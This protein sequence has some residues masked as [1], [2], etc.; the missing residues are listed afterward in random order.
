MTLARHL[1]VGNDRS[2]N[3]LSEATLTIRTS[4]HLCATLGLV[5]LIR[6][7][8]DLRGTIT[9]TTLPI[10]ALVA[11][12][13][14]KAI[15]GG[16]PA[17]RSTGIWRGPRWSLWNEALPGITSSCRTDTSTLLERG[18]IRGTFQ[19]DC[20]DLSSHQSC[21]NSVMR[22]GLTTK[23]GAHT[24]SRPVWNNTN[25]TALSRMN[26]LR[27]GSHGR[28]RPARFPPGDISLL[29]LLQNDGLGR[30]Q[31]TTVRSHRCG[32]ENEKRKTRTLTM[33]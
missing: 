1:P 5:R 23:I 33:G 9:S 24:P 31:R 17:N 6:H 30:S 4:T 25:L 8:R 19:Q 20:S 32:R 2:R 14:R 15:R 13:G 7:R 16:T 26:T 12:V 28:Q 18:K 29:R 22:T 27:L 10:R 21:S 3:L 11:I